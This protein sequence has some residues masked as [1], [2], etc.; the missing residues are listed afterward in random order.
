[1]RPPD[2]QKEKTALRFHLQIMD[3]EDPA[4]WA[5]HIF[6]ESF[7]HKEVALGHLTDADG[8]GVFKRWGPFSI[9]PDSVSLT[10]LLTFYSSGGDSSLENVTTLPSK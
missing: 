2:L 4:S 10:D 3:L 7:K 6:S 1:M 9:K 5:I 8:V